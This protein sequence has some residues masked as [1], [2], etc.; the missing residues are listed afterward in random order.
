MKIHYKDK[1]IEIKLNEKMELVDMPI[2]AMSCIESW[3]IGFKT[4]C[5][6]AKEPIELWRKYRKEIERTLDVMENI[7]KK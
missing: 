7:I 6:T 3:L 5:M 1:N 2:V 4:Y